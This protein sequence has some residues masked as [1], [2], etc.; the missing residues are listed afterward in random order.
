MGTYY[1]SKACHLHHIHTYF[2]KF[3]SKCFTVSH[4][5][6]R[7]VKD[8]T[9]AFSYGVLV[10]LVKNNLTAREKLPC[11]KCPRSQTPSFHIA[12]SSLIREINAQRDMALL[13][14]VHASSDLTKTNKYPY[15]HSHQDPKTAH[16]VTYRKCK[17]V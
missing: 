6:N 13:K 4:A 7:N 17:T 3:G 1:R 10:F 12:A 14:L 9:T 2:F 16:T 15:Q 5:D 11:L 8:I